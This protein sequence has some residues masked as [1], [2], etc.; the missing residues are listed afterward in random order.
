MEIKTPPKIHAYVRLPYLKG[1]V[2]MAHIPWALSQSN[3]LNCII[4]W[5]SF[6]NG[7][8]SPQLRLYIDDVICRFFKVGR[9]VCLYHNRKFLR[10]LK[11]VN[12]IYFLDPVKTKSISPLENKIV[13]F[14]GYERRVDYNHLMPSKCEKCPPKYRKLNKNEN[15]NAPKLTN[16]HGHAYHIYTAWCNYSW[17]MYGL[18]TKCGVK[19]AGYW[20]GSQKENEENIQPTWPNKLGQ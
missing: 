14:L 3:S 16:S 12:I 11:D 6:Y 10:W 9:S 7:E 1:M 13:I 19:M 15:K 5:P 8:Y 17:Y 2:I 20:P 18:L 4:Q